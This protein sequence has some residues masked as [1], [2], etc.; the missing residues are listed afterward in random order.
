[1]KSYRTNAHAIKVILFTVFLMGIVL[2][3]HQANANIENGWSGSV[4][5]GIPAITKESSSG[6]PFWCNQYGLLHKTCRVTDISPSKR[7]A[8]VNQPRPDANCPNGVW[9]IVDRLSGVAMTLYPNDKVTFEEYCR[10]N[11][12]VGFVHTRNPNSLADVVMYFNNKPVESLE[13]VTE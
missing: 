13:Y 4:S 12:K 6:K 3:A 5:G 9:G 8:I 1:M 7:I 11:F 2:F 10:G